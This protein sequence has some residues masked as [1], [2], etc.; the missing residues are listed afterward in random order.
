M[1]C[2]RL[3]VVNPVTPH[4]DAFFSRASDCPACIACLRRMFADKRDNSVAVPDLRA[5]IRSPY[6]IPRVLT[7][8]LR[9]HTTRSATL[10]L[11]F[12]HLS[13]ANLSCSANE[14]KIRMLSV[15]ASLPPPLIACSPLRL[16]HQHASAF[17]NAPRPSTPPDPH[18]AH[19]SGSCVSGGEMLFGETGATL[20]RSCAQRRASSVRRVTACC[21]VFLAK[22]KS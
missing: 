12:D 11:F 14:M 17:W 5:T 8:H 19:V 16:D 6:E 3:I 9:E 4:R 18:V 2:P 15:I 21:D 10:L 22:R 13:R 1:V 7:N 20:A